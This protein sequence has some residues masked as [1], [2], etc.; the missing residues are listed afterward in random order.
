MNA[1]F[2][3][4]STNRAASKLSLVLSKFI[5]I[6]PTLPVMTAQVFVQIATA[7]GSG[8][9]FKDLERRMGLQS[10]TVSRNVSILSSRSWT[11]KPGLD[12]VQAITDPDDPR[13]KIARLNLRGRRIWGTLLE[14][15]EM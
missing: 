15:L 13:A 1:T 11:G 4:R 2:E 9:R 7:G 5:E 10:G 3:G 14:T 6:S 12:L 8:I